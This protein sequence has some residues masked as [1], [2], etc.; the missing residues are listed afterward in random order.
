MTFIEDLHESIERRLQELRAEIAKIEDARHALTNGS[1]KPAAAQPQPAAANPRRR[2]QKL[3]VITEEQ[4]QLI[5]SGSDDGLST[6]AIA[7]QGHAD[8]AQVLA[9][10]RKQEAAGQVRRSGERRGTRWHLI[11]DVDRIADRAAELAARSG[12]KSSV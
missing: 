3:K 10:L 11:T 1:A 5:L 6:A 4:L 8:A 2:R 9:V 7:A 12:A